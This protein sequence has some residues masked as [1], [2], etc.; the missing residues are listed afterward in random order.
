MQYARGKKT[1]QLYAYIK[2]N[3]YIKVK[4]NVDKSGEIGSITKILDIV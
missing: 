2:S 4:E 1:R 3:A